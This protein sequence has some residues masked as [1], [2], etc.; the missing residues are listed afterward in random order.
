MR[1]KSVEGRAIACWN[2]ETGTTVWALPGKPHLVPLAAAGKHRF[3]HDRRF[4]AAVGKGPK[5]VVEYTVARVA[6]RAKNGT[7]LVVWEGSQ[8]EDTWEPEAAIYA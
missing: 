1:V 6:K 3:R 5:A 4:V 7:V 8:F 2:S